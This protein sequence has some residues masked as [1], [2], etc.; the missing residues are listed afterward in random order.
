MLQER[1]RRWLFS[2]RVRN[3]EQFG[4]IGS[5]QRKWDSD[6]LDSPYRFCVRDG[7]E[8]LVAIFEIFVENLLGFDGH[9]VLVA[10]QQRSLTNINHRQPNKHN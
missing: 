6:K 1:V 5:G 9:N 4:D 8:V 3:S 2:V 7:H 10:N